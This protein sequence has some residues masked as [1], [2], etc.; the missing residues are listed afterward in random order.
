MK[1]NEFN[2][3]NNYMHDLYDLNNSYDKKKKQQSTF[4]NKG[5][6]IWYRVHT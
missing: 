3:L 4:Y 1:M 5:F 2:A 6:I